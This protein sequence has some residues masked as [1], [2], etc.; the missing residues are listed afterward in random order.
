MERKLLIVDG[1]SIL[2][3]A[4]YNSLTKEVE[5]LHS[6]RD[7]G[8]QITT[9]E[10]NRI[11]STLLQSKKGTSI[12]AVQGFFRVLF[13]ALDK[14]NPSHLIV[15]WGAQREN[16]FRRKL[17]PGYKDDGKVKDRELLSQE[18]L[19]KELLKDMGMCQLE[20]E[21]REALDLAGCLIEKYKK[22]FKIELLARNT[23]ALQFT[24]DAV[25]W[26]RLPHFEDIK[27]RFNLDCSSFPINSIRF[28]EEFLLKYKNLKPHQLPDYRALTGHS[29]SKIPGVKSIG[30]VTTLALLEEYESIENIY[31]DIDACGSQHELVDFGNSLTKYL[32]LP[33]NPVQYLVKGRE[34]AFLGKKLATYERDAASVS[35]IALNES[36][37]S[38]NCVEKVTIIKRLKIVCLAPVTCNITKG[39]AEKIENLK[40]SALIVVYNHNLFSINSPVSIGTIDNIKSLDLISFDTI[41]CNDIREIIKVSDFAIKNL[42]PK[43]KFTLPAT[44]YYSNKEVEQRINVHIKREEEKKKLAQAQ[45]QTASTVSVIGAVCQTA[46]PVIVNNNIACNECE[47]EIEEEYDEIVEEEVLVGEICIAEVEECETIAVAVTENNTQSSNSSNTPKEA[48]SSTNDVNSQNTGLSLLEQLVINRYTCN[49]CGEEFLLVNSTAQYCVKCGKSN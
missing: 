12:N 6:L 45:T 41:S 44:G 1:T 14:T 22:D 19:T 15:T 27:R 30:D 21:T 17:F 47:E 31:T 10:E 34:E 16:N 9:E 20:S 18:A 29:F 32:T 37:F 3:E 49:H 4:Y 46:I 23:L 26:L 43:I 33:F 35:L 38:L 13:D 39:L 11:F 8:K 42:G 7:S 36:E 48:V 40:F 28:D 24:D 25:V 2:A 5:E